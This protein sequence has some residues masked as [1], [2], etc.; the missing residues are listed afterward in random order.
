MPRKSSTSPSQ[1]RVWRHNSMNGQLRWAQS[2][3]SSFLSADTLTDEARRKTE[4]V[5]AHISDLQKLMK[6]RKD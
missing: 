5:L 4:I 1:Q 6:T 3:I 2:A